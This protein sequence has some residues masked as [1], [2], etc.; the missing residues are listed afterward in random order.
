MLQWNYKLQTTK[1]NNDN[2]TGILDSWVESWFW[3]DVQIDAKVSPNF[4]WSQTSS[5]LSKGPRRQEFW[6]K[7]QPKALQ[8]VFSSKFLPNFLLQ[9]RRV[10]WRFF[11]SF[12]WTREFFIQ[13]EGDASARSPNL[14]TACAEKLLHTKN[15]MCCH[16]KKKL[17]WPSCCCINRKGS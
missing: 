14:S 3:S 12:G 6:W 11:H 2:P 9:A 13:G 4:S 10:C 1:G 15:T 5:D 7:R 17:I 16:V 8:K